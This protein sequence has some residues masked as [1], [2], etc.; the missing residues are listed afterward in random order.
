M[1]K[2]LHVIS[3]VL[4]AMVF[5]QNLFPAAPS[6]VES[7]G[8][9]YMVEVEVVMSEDTPLRTSHDVAMELQHKVEALDNVERAFVHVDY[10]RRDYWEHKV[11]GR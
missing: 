3:K 1:S 7:F 8:H 10:A 4:H 6:H 11:R 9:R 5:D 2:V